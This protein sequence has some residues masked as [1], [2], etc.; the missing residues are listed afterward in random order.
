MSSEITAETRRE[1]T[2]PYRF[3]EAFARLLSP[4]L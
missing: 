2:M 1:L 4:V 3:A